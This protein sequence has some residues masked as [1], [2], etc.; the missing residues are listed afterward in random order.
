M[1]RSLFAGMA[2][3]AAVIALLFAVAS[4]TWATF[5]KR[6]GGSPEKAAEVGQRNIPGRDDAGDKP[7]DGKGNWWDG[8][9]EGGGGETGRPTSVLGP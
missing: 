4:D 1:K 6:G 8:A 7:G 2:G 3:A 9:F 5:D